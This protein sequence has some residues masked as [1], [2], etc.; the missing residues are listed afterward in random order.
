LDGGDLLL[1]LSLSL[2]LSPLQDPSL[3][4]QDEPLQSHAFP[5]FPTL[6]FAE[7]NDHSQTVAKLEVGAQWPW[8]YRGQ[9]QG[10]GQCVCTWRYRYPA[11]LGTLKNFVPFSVKNEIE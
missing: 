5:S 9:G 11:N 10:Q 1:S 2:S 7:L 3:S 8:R 6:G 4:I